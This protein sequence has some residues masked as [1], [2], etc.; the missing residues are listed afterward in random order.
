[1]NSFENSIIVVEF[2]KAYHIK[3]RLTTRLTAFL[4]LPFP[5][6]IIARKCGSGAGNRS[7]KMASFFE[8]IKPT[9]DRT[10][11]PSGKAGQQPRKLG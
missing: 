9:D 10:T 1:M 11:G 7:A 3:V 8:E 2:S 6:V 4:N 5:P